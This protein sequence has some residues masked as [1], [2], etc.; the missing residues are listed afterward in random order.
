MK[1][2]R[3][4]IIAVSSFLVGCSTNYTHII[5]PLEIHYDAISNQKIQKSLIEAANEYSKYDVL[6]YAMFDY[7]FPA[8]ESEYKQMEGCGIIWI[9][10]LS[11]NVKEL[12]INNVRLITNSVQVIELPMYYSFRTVEKD[13]LISKVFGKFRIDEIYLIPFHDGV[14]SSSLVL[15]YARNR[16][17][18]T[19]GQLEKSF[20]NKWGKLIKLS[21]DIT[22]PNTEDY[23]DVLMREYPI[24]KTVK[25]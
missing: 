8:D 4:I 3:I 7:A 5:E 19:I 12:P 6:R 15:D 21:S 25:K 22:Y 1:I 10:A 11:H 9:T 13:P 23:V 2:I 20:P 18:F 14:Q 24:I 17:N 16:K